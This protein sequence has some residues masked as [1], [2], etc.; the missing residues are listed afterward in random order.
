[1]SN[2]ETIQTYHDEIWGQKDISSIDRY[3]SNK[4]IIHSAIESTEGTE[5]M[6]SVIAKWS[7]AL[8]ID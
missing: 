4:A 6:K 3:F 8:L 2:L 7:T 5:N 1:M